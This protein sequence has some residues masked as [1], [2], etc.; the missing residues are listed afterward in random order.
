MINN[1][2][3]QANSA[4]TISVLQYNLIKTKAL[5]IGSPNIIAGRGH[6]IKVARAKKGII[7]SSRI[8]LLLK[9][10][11]SFSGIQVNPFV[12]YYFTTNPAGSFHEEFE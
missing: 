10:S 9:R 7:K 8:H 12:I 1:T 5:S 11:L 3:A 2:T 4:N 6:V